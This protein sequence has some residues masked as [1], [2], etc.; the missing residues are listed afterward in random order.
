MSPSP[1]GERRNGP[2]RHSRPRR[3]FA[4]IAVA[5]AVAVGGGIAL[6]VLL[7]GGGQPP[8]P[9]PR[10]A[11]PQPT[12]SS[13]TRVGVPPH[14]PQQSPPWGFT[15]GASPI[16]GG[17]PDIC[18]GPVVRRGASKQQRVP[19][20]QSCRPGSRRITGLTQ[21]ALTARAG[22]DTDRLEAIW[23]AIE[24][25]SPSEAAERGAPRFN[26]A[27]LVSRY[28]S[29]IQ[30]GIRPIVV[31]SGAPAW[32]RA[33]GWDRSGACTGCSFPPARQRLAQWR[34][35]LRALMAHL[36]KMSAL[37]VWN[38]PNYSTFFAPHANPSLYAQL[39]QAADKA[40][41]ESD[42]RPP[43]VTGGLSPVPPAG[44][45]MPPAQF[46]SRVYEIA[47]KRSFDGI[48]AH[49]YPV[50]PPWIP[51]MIKNLD[52]LRRVSE[53][54]GDASKPLWITEVGIGGIPGG[55]GRFNVPLN[56]QGPVLARMYRATQRMNIRSFLIYT[57]S[58]L[59]GSISR[60]ATYGVLDRALRPK[61]AY[62]YLAKRIGGK[63]TC[64]STT[65]RR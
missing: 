3:P 54:F 32:A 29:M 42:S 35:F 10:P 52:Q 23:A 50:R 9:G 57:L 6:A 26:W 30:D 16:G 36:P 28:R 43:I 34:A 60:F 41:R 14:N 64:P 58:E 53:R 44:G 11:P 63:Q 15:G 20:A 31:A 21:I 1:A 25:L 55:R 22:A 27:P 5:A 17:W 59:G 62:C 13:S 46:L 4:P 19:D 40:A 24:P 37:E 7:Q 45:K 8:T 51:G 33:P 12:T 2:G 49:P 38:E 56:R 47:G 18:Y 48:G 39:L 61:P 65:P